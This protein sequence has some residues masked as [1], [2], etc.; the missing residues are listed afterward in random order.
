VDGGGLTDTEAK[1]LVT[2]VDV[3]VIGAG[4]AGIATSVALKRAGLTSFLVLER[5]ASIGGVWRDNIYPGAACD[6]PSLLYSF[7]FETN[8]QW[9]KVFA[10]QPEIRAYLERC[11]DKY[12]LREHIRFNTEV[13]RLSYNEADAVWSVYTSDA[14]VIR[15]LTVLTAVGQLNR[16]S[17]PTLPGIENFEG[18]AFHSARWRGDVELKGKSVAV[19]GTGA[20]AIQI[21]PHIAQIAAR[22]M[23]FQR[24]PPWVMPKPDRSYLE[25]EKRR[26][27]RVP[28]LAR[29]LRAR[30]WWSYESGHGKVIAGTKVN[31][32][33]N[34]PTRAM[35]TVAAI[36]SKVL[37][38]TPLKVS[39]GR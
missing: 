24:S 16:P 35:I 6:V 33:M 1:T 21:V 29:M 18:S 8:T 28:L 11:V 4:P 12:G 25:N 13:I 15:T 31:D 36:G 9:S 3:V 17:T 19:V 10:P 32:R 26:F 20:S 27:K 34:A 38:S 14:G 2:T 30:L 39:S 22:L 7:S 37:P 5:E 23:V